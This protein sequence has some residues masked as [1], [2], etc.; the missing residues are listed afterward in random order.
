MPLK[1]YLFQTDY[2]QS[3]FMQGQDTLVIRGE[4]TTEGEEKRVGAGAVINTSEQG[5][6][7]YVGVTS[8]GLKEQREALQN[9]YSR[10]SGM[11]GKLM[12]KTQRESGE[13]LTVRVGSSTASLNQI[14]LTSA[15]ALE[16]T[17]KQAGK[18][19]GLSD[20]Q[21][22]EISVVPNTDFIKELLDGKRFL[23]LQQAK[24]LGFPISEESLHQLAVKNEITSKTFDEEKE[25]IESEGPSAGTV[26]GVNLLE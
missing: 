4:T 24:N 6:A 26:S 10:S 7:E 20:E 3:L 19:H 11:R 16:T 5:G 23:E 25:A 22:D 18:W 1:H 14:V 13:A 12:D 8:D 2:R 15:E 9:D 17:L 21:I